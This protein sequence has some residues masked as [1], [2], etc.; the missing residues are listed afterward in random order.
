TNT[1]INAP[2]ILTLDSPPRPQESGAPSAS[3]QHPNTAPPPQVGPPTSAPPNS[4][5]N[6]P[7]M[8]T[9]ATNPSAFSQR[10]PAQSPSYAQS[11][12]FAPTPS[13][14]PAP[15]PTPQRR[16]P[17][18]PIIAGVFGLLLLIGIGGGL[19]IWSRM[20]GETPAEG[21]GTKTNVPLGTGK[22]TTEPNTTA[23]AVETMRY[24][25]E[26]AAA[27]PGTPSA[28][29]AGVMPLAS[30]QKFK[31]HVMPREDG[32]LYIIGPGEGNVPTTFLTAKPV[33]VS[34]VDTNEVKASADFA[35]PN[36][37][38]NWIQL[39]KTA[40]TEFWTIIFSPTPLASPAFLNAEA[41]SELS[42]AE[43]SEFEGFRA[44]H[45]ANAPIIDVINGADPMVSVK[46]PAA[47]QAGEPVVFDI[48]IEHK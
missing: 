29:V 7:P 2:T 25:L 32:H 6:A 39:D 18:V 42:A 21:T 19:L 4:Y 41:G 1:D 24:W 34:G 16:S 12:S 33:E 22:E 10:E 26:V 38:D 17:V 40:G 23:E 9:V 20:G 36:G 45:K 27:S 3:A 30:G 35:F 13:Y 8:A 48:R 43:Q 15:Q 14:A 37:E 5:H 46:V 11:P 28:R 47:K 31:F 44:E